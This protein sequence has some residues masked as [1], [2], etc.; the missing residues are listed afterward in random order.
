MIRLNTSYQ[1]KH[2]ARLRSRDLFPTDAP[3]HSEDLIGREAEVSDLARALAGGMNRIIAGPRRTGKTSVCR[4]VVSRLRASDLYTVE[5]D[6][7]AIASRAELAQ[8]LVEET[9]ANR[10]IFQRALHGVGR[11]GRAVVKGA[12]LSL[13]AKAKAEFGEEIEIAFHP[14]LAAR[15]PDRY[16]SWALRLPQRVAEADDRQMVL[17]VDEFQELA[18]P[19]H[20]YGHPDTLTK[21]MRSVL[22]DSDRVTCLFAGSIEH[23]MRDLFTPAHRA[24]YQF[25]GFQTL[26]PIAAED[27]RAG[28][29]ARFAHDGCSVDPA[30]LDRLIELGEGHPRATMLVAQQTH[31]AAIAAETT[32]VDLG[33]VIVGYEVAMAS[34]RA[35]H[36]LTVEH[37]R[38]LG[39]HTLAVVRRLAQAQRA[40]PGIESKTATRAVNSLRD[41][42]IIERRGRGDWRVTDPLLR[43][44]LA[45]F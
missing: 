2:V 33:L 3:L 7:F 4:A 29:G 6:L 19:R 16:L 8:R 20:P 22:Q 12:S 30:V 42:G 26:G 9:I 34:D 23:L 5:C 35:N 36:E 43:R 38:A 39:R 31:D 41:A 44:Y 24:F 37:V 18:G 1:E 45:D 11:A 21:Q 40:Y 15:D 10:G 32:D 17:F 13:A 28:L 25:G 27:W 14:G